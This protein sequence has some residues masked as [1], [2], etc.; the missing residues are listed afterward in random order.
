MIKHVITMMI[1]INQFLS[2]QTTAVADSYWM[3]GG[4]VLRNTLPP[5]WI[6]LCTLVRMKIPVQVVYKGVSEFLNSGNIQN[7]K[8]NK[9]RN[10]TRVRRSYVPD[11]RVYLD[12]IGQP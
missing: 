4:D 5:M 12:A 10:G 11:P 2:E 7:D 6:G 1:P 3:C 8:Q 9:S